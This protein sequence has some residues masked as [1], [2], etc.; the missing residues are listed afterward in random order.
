MSCDVTVVV[1]LY[2]K[3][4]LWQ[5]FLRGDIFLKGFT[6]LWVIHLWHWWIVPDFVVSFFYRRWIWAP[7]IDQLFISG[8][9]VMLLVSSACQRLF[10]MDIPSRY[11]SCNDPWSDLDWRMSA[12]SMARQSGLSTWDTIQA[13]GFSICM[14][15]HC[16]A[17]TKALRVE[18][19]HVWMLLLADNH[20]LVVIFKCQALQLMFD[21]SVINHFF[22]MWHFRLYQP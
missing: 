1:S 20:P 7:Y 10:G 14:G 11:S 21:D 4:N 19:N 5:W 3:S 8:M 16:T 17:F 13:T 12:K 6:S 9:K 2:P 18:S 15:I 22:L